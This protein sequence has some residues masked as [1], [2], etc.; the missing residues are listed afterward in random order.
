MNIEQIRARSL[1]YAKRSAPLPKRQARKQEFV[2]WFA[3]SL[4]GK[5]KS[6]RVPKNSPQFTREDILKMRTQNGGFRRETLAMLGVN[7]PP[8]KGW[9]KRYLAGQDPNS[10]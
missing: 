4:E 6:P 1:E 10:T 2:N 8:Q 9:M 5:E 7:W 3:D